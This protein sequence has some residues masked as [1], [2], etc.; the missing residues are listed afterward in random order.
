MRMHMRR[1]HP[2]NWNI[3]ISG[4]ETAWD[5]ILT[6]IIRTKS[7]LRNE[8]KLQIFVKGYIKIK[9]SC[10]AKSLIKPGLSIRYAE[11]SALPLVCAALLNVQCTCLVVLFV[12]TRTLDETFLWT[13][14][15]PFEENDFTISLTMTSFVSG[16]KPRVNANIPTRIADCFS[17]EACEWKG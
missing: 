12:G 14:G 7:P 13:K 11:C 5:S 4:T 2:E 17:I 9:C 10:V 1:Q 3:L 15:N 6:K 8:L 16:S